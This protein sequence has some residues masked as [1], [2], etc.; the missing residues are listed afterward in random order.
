MNE[1]D[2]NERDTSAPPPAPCIVHEGI[3]ASRLDMKRVLA[4]LCN[5]RY[6]YQTED[7][8]PYEGEGYIMDVFA[9]PQSST[10]VANHAIYINLLSF[11]Y[12]QIARP[13]GDETRFTLVGEGRRL[14]L[15]PLSN[16]MKEQSDRT[17]QV[18]A[19]E[20]VVAEV[21]SAKL[22]AQMDDDELAW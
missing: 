16:P 9:H 17:L 6:A 22:D 19:L 7:D 21:L 15:V 20:A 1:R 2:R 13:P 11:D 12:L 8:A 10:I 3:L 4:D 18:S 5:V 14:Q